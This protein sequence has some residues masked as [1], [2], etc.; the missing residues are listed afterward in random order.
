MRVLITGAS[1][2]IGAAVCDALLE[3]GDE[4][5]GLSRNPEAARSREPRVDW[6]GWN[7]ALERPPAE[8]LAGVDG[9]INLL[10]EPINQRWSD[11]ARQRISESRETATRN[12]VDAIAAADAKPKVL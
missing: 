8:A 9:V 11:A 1:G 4:V 7:P 3:R 2:A 5:V 6:Q 12:L 10:G